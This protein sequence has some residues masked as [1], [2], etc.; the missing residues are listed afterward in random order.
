M[1]YALCIS[2]GAVI[3]LVIFTNKEGNDKDMIEGMGIDENGKEISAQEDRKNLP[4]IS[5]T[6]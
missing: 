4:P 2:T 1:N 3:P 6:M 5:L